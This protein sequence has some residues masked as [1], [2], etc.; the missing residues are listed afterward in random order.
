MLE[1][2]ELENIK[3]G[4]DGSVSILEG[5]NPRIQML[6]CLYFEAVITKKDG[7]FY[8]IQETSCKDGW[9]VTE[10]PY[11]CLTLE[12]LEELEVIAVENYLNNRGIAVPNPL[13]VLLKS[14]N[15]REEIIYFDK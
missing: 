6:Y 7:R 2:K 10:F 15:T 13:E 11:K 8:Y 5:I 1:R 4:N 9:Q 3:M 14:D 12:F